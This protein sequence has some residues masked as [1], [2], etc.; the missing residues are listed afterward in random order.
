MTYKALGPELYDGTSGVLTPVTGGPFQAMAQI[1]GESTGKYIIGITAQNGA[2][3]NADSHVYVFAITSGTG[4]LTGPTAFVT[5][6]P[7]VDMAVSPSGLFVYTFEED[8][9]GV[10]RTDPMEGFQLSST[11]QLTALAGLSPF[12]TLLAS[13]GK[14]DQS[15]QYLFAKELVSGNIG[16]GVYNANTTTGALTSTLPILGP[17]DDNYVVTDAP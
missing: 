7:P 14:F 15:G 10:S 2:T 12:T 9:T 3:S 16:R 8:F 4:A 13:Q 11:G 1:S 5:A 17:G 6:F